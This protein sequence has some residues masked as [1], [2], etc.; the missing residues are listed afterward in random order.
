VYCELT[1]PDGSTYRYGSEDAESTVTGD[2]GA[3][4]RV[5]ARRLAPDDAGLAASGPH[6]ATALRL[7][8][9]YAA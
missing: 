3:F 9:T 7:L 8:R 2:L 1:G 5:G 6:G 4:C